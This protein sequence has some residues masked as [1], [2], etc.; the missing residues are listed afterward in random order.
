MVGPGAATS[1]LYDAQLQNDPTVDTELPSRRTRRATHPSNNQPGGPV[2]I[3]RKQP[4]LTS[5][6]VA[7]AS[8]GSLHQKNSASS[9]GLVLYLVSVGILAA[10]IVSVFFGSGF[11]LLVSPAIRTM[12]ASS[13]G[14]GPEGPF[15]ADRLFSTSES[16]RRPAIAALPSSTDM[17]AASQS[18]ATLPS[19]IEAP[20]AGTGVSPARV[21]TDAL[22]A[23]TPSS[24]VAPASATVPSTLAATVHAPPASILS[25]SEIVEL[26]EHGDSLLR[27]GDIASARLFYERAAAAGEGRAAL[28]LGATYD[29]AFLNRAGL[30]N[31]QAD[32]VQARS[33][34][35]RALEL[36]DAEAKKLLNGVEAK[37]GD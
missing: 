5:D 17:G 33:W 8:E 23:M 26:L 16:Y 24:S 36:G 13:I 27:T 15:P 9:V 2:A 6:I 21:Q 18:A 12:N 25:A 22:T 32:P 7:S 1:S 4:F 19:L 35:S 3:G 29:P 20:I 10:L 30:G 28:R 34:Y 37:H 14:A 31:M 11:L